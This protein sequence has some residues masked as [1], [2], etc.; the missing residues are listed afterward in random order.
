[1]R[2]K[3][4]GLVFQ[5]EDDICCVRGGTVAVTW[6]KRT[7]PLFLPVVEGMIVRLASCGKVSRGCARS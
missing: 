5:N 3:R 7:R 4:K 1:M 2:E 6:D